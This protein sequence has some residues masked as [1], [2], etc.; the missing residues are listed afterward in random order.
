MTEPISIETLI[1]D[2]KLIISRY[3]K[4]LLNKEY[5]VFQGAFQQVSE[6]LLKHCEVLEALESLDRELDSGDSIIDGGEF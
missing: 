1:E 2:Q 6:T 5:N 4:G 3:Q